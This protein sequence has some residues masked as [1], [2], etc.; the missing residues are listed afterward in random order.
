MGGG[1]GGVWKCEGLGY[2]VQGLTDNSGIPVIMASGV[3]GRVCESVRRW[4]MLRRALSKRSR[5]AAL[6][7]CDITRWRFENVGMRED[8][9]P[10]PILGAGGSM[11]GLDKD[12]ARPY[13]S[14]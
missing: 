6:L 3:G 14:F 4:T 1:W 13:G 2:A 5:G 7:R 10:V 8:K 9:A 12:V 11:Q